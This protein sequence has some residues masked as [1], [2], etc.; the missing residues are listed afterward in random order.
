MLLI[1]KTYEIITPESAEHGDAEE[2]GFEFQDRAV[3]FREL[4]DM[5]EHDGFATAS[6]WPCRGDARDW[7][8]TINPER[9]YATGQDTYYSLHLSHNASPR[10]AKYWRK[11]LR[12]HGLAQ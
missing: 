10:A 11:A 4:I 3:S 1:N 8:S 6:C 5:I 2:R 9:N 12:Y 7:I